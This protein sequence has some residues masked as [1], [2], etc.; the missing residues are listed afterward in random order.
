MTILKAEPRMA[1]VVSVAV[2]NDE[3]K[4]QFSDGRR[5]SVP[6]SWYPRLFHAT[7]EE[8]NNWR[9]IGQGDGV[10]WP[11]LDEDISAANIIFG[12]PSGE[13][14]R[15]LGKWMKARGTDGG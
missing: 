15:S 9:L 5:V 3:L 11:A 13:S 4:A 1:D 10:H 7:P 2:T 6:L 14:Q 12:Q 8:R